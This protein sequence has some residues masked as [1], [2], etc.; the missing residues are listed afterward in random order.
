MGNQETSSEIVDLIIVG[1]GSVGLTMA[2]TWGRMG[3]TGIVLDKQPL[4]Y[5]LPRAGHIDH[6][7]MRFLQQ[8]DAEE[9]VLEDGFVGEKYIWINGVGET[10]LSFPWEQHSISGWAS[11]YMLNSAVLEQSLIERVDEAASIETFRG[12]Q[13]IDLVQHADHV[14][15]TIE[16]TAI[17]PDSPVPQGTGERRTLRG[18]YLVAADGANSRL[19]QHLGIGRDD[20]GFNERWLVVDARMTRPF[21]L[22][23]DCGQVCDPRRPTTVLPLG[24]S[25]RRWEWH[26]RPEEDAEE[27]LRPEKVWE[28]L[29]PFGITDEDV[30]PV[31]HLIYTF[32]ARLAREW[33]S[34]RVF[35]A[36]D[37]A[38][39]MPPF[40]GQGMC[41]GMRDARNLA[42]KFD[43][44][45]KGLADDSLL[46]S[47]QIER[48][49]H[50]RDWTVISLES[51]KIPCIVDEEQARRRDEMFRNGYTPPLPEF[52]Q[53]IAGVLHRDESGA[54]A[55]PAGENG[56]QA[57]VTRGT[58][59]ALLDEFVEPFTFSVISVGPDPRDFL[60]DE[61]ISVLER[62]GVSWIRLDPS[63]APR[64]SLGAGALIDADDSYADYLKEKQIEF[65]LVR[66]DL[67]VFG[68]SDRDGLPLLVDDLLGQVAAESTARA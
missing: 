16:A 39:T 61:Q 17:V 32:E 41:S 46:D 50:V 8:V 35:L 1:A 40:L 64:D 38:H 27:F 33:R 20:L 37:A 5:G 62:L 68:G 26:L 56:I 45:L 14:E 10:L 28:L 53:L 13:A 52:P 30:V 15:L 63:D 58:E 4:P 3:R 51:G 48:E 44:V 49:P 24:N 25:H 12:W 34:G 67:Y 57:R 31:R 42:W 18:R 54:L 23:F 29:E 2:A 11:D 59:T 19:R 21:S 47:Y 60:R 65:V 55:G 66:P 6:E 7:I 43:L 22:P 36:G 9:P